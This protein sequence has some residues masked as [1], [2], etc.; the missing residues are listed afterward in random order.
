MAV[1]K[2]GEKLCAACF[3]GDRVE[4]QKPSVDVLFESAAAL[5][6]KAVGVILTGMGMDGAKGLL[7]MRGAGAATFG[8]DKE[9]SVVYG[10]PMRAFEMNAVAKQLPL[11]EI[12]KNILR[13]VGY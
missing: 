11:G 9:T 5:G 12:A 10:M 7:K 4:G 13:A 2:R 6:P 3:D 1:A 8:Q